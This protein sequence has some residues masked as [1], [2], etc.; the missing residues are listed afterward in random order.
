MKTRR[1]VRGGKAFT[2]VEMLVVI[3]V[4]AVLVAMILPKFA[5]SKGGP[6]GYTCVSNLKQIGLAYRIWEGDN[7]DKF[8]MQ[9]SVTNGGTM[10][11]FSSGS[12]FSQFAFL[13]FV[14][15]S[16][17][18]STPKF[19]HCPADPN[20]IAAAN[21][22][23]GFSDTNISYF[24]GLDVTPSK[25][26]MILAG[27]DNLAVNG[28]RIYPGILSLPTNSSVTWTKERHNGTGNILLAD[29]SVQS[30]TSDSLKSA[31]A[32][33]AATNRLVIP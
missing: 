30:I 3:V 23:T 25:P 33:S 11:L 18:L 22:A 10:E 32:N 24:F 13:N 20:H 28:V 4:L 19:L 16:N 1:T 17:E 29:G 9:V 8:P 31:L 12:Q 6:G 5:R 2:L 26:Q 7:G 27:D 14:A 21:F 15:M